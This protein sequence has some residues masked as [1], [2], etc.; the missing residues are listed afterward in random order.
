MPKGLDGWLARRRP[1]I[2]A[3]LLTAACLLRLGVFVELNGGPCLGMDRFELT[4]MHFFRQ[5]AR[6]IT[7][8]DWL[9]DRSLHPLHEWHR[10]IAAAYFAGYPEARANFPGDDRAV[11]QALWN[12]WYGGKGFHQEPLYPYLIALTTG[13]LGDDVRWVFLWQSL[14]GIGGV[15]LLFEISRR[16]WSDRVALVA[17]VLAVGYGPLIFSEFTLLRTAII[18]WTGLFLVWLLLA[19]QNRTSPGRWFGVGAAL[20]LAVLLKS[21]FLLLALGVLAATLSHRPFGWRTALRTA[22]AVLLGLGLPLLGVVARNLA[23]GAPIGQLSAV[24]TITFVEANVASHRP[25]EGFTFSVAHTPTILH[26]SGGRFLPAVAETLATHDGPISYLRLLASKW[27]T[28]WTWFEYPNNCNFYYFQLHSSVLRGLP[29]S[30]GLLA[31]LA[32]A[33]IFLAAR[34]NGGR[35]WLYLLA[36]MHLLGMMATY[37]IARFRIPLAA[38]LIPFAALALVQLARWLAACRFRPALI[39]LLA[40]ILM[41]AWVYRPLNKPLIRPGDHLVAYAVHTIPRYEAAQAR[42]DWAACARILAESLSGVPD[43]SAL[44]RAAVA[45]LTGDERRL[46]RLLVQVYGL[47]A[48]ALYRIGETRAAVQWRERAEELRRRL[49]ETEKESL[50]PGRSGGS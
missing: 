9:T 46:A 25:G 15:F 3:V 32:L 19:N 45:R 43:H 13:L 29:V 2:L 31:P 28:L 4:D 38:A 7:A 1:L 22:A 10:Q 26:R 16:L 30:F 35:H 50:V 27:L 40:V 37:V 33:G 20:G 5:W 14:L 12:R 47:Y 48:G 44:D 42:A 17:G 34:K 6:A 8:G 21:I 23:V 49:E 18:T 24:N 39:L 36:G 41:G 11:E